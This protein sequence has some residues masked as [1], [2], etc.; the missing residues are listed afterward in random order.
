MH[1]RAVGVEDPR[2]ADVDAV[3]AVVVEEQR[4]G[5]ALAFVVAGARADRVDAAPVA[6][7]LRVD[8]R[9]AVD[10]AGRGLED[11]R[12]ASAWRDPS[13]LIAPCTLVF[14]VCTG[15]NW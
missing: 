13:M 14:I 8:R 7:G 12:P 10:L 9:V 2:D 5:A 11:P 3:L 15:S 1:P 4:L 6:L